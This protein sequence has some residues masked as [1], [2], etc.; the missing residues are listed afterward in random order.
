M[1][2][3]KTFNQTETDE[4]I[5]KMEHGL[6]VKLDEFSVPPEL[7]AYFAKIGYSTVALFQSLATSDEGV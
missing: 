2:L 1:P 6:R 5:G 7:H 4:L 3:N